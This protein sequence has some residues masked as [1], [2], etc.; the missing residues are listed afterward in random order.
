M[1]VDHGDDDRIQLHKEYSDIIYLKGPTSLWWTG[2][3]N[4]GIRY[5]LKKNATHI[6]LLNNDCYLNKDTLQKLVEHSKENPSAIFAP[7][8]KD[9]YTKKVLAVRVR[10]LFVFGFPTLI[11]PW[12]KKLSY[13]NEKKIST[14]MILGGRGAL[15]P[16][17]IINECGLFDENNLPHYGADHDF[18]LRCRKKNVPLFTTS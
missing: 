8:Q 6:V 14:K 3:T 10:T 13:G 7:V 9:F 15:I 17:K 18:Y 12:Y 2:A 16:V 5:A 4:L 1:L 11:L